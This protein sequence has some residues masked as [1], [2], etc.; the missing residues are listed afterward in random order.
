VFCCTVSKKLYIT[1]DDQIEELYVNGLA[2]AVGGGG[3]EIV[4]TV[5]VPDTITSIA[6]KAIDLYQV[7]G[8][9]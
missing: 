8:A 7:S 6:V 9:F 2:T 5:D 1:A 4:R 3:W